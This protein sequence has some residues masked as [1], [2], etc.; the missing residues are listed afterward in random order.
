MSRFDL[1]A[2]L[3]VL[4]CVSFVVGLRDVPL[5][6]AAIGVV[7]PPPPED[8][9]ER[10][11]KLELV[12]LAEGG[13]PLADATVRVLWEQ[14][15]R[16]YLAGRAVTDA[17]G[18][19]LFEGL[20]RG[21]AWILVDAAGKARGSSQVV[22]DDQARRLE[23]VLGDSH[24]LAVSVRDEQ[25]EPLGE[26]TVLV[27]SADPL[28]YGA[29]TDPRG[30][31]RFEQLAASPWTI[32]VSAAGYESV[33]RSGVVSDLTLELRRLGSLEVRVELASGKPA[34]GASVLIAGSALW[35]ARRT[36][37]DATGATRIAGL[38]SGSYDLRATLGELVSPTLHGFQLERGAHE[39]LTLRLVTGRMVRALVVD[40]DDENA[41]V[42]P[43][44]DVVLAESGL[45]SFPLRGRT[46]SDGTVLLGPIGP[47]I[48]TLAA[49]AP[50][51]VSSSA[52]AVPEKL[53]GPLRIPLVRGGSLLGEVVDTKD[54]PVDGASVEVVGTDRDGL[55][56][57][58]TPTLLGF[59]L[60]HFEWSL[61]G[62]TPLIPAGELGVMPG[63]VPPIPPPGA[64]IVPGGIAGA[65]PLPAGSQPEAELEPWVTRWDGSFTARP[66]TPGRVRALVRHPAFVE[67]LSEVVTL[68]PGGEAKVKVVLRTGGA[69]E[70]RVVDSFGRPQAGVRVDLTALR[71][72]LERTTSTAN[73]GSFAFAAVPE[74]VS[75]SLARP[76]DPSRIVF[77]KQVQAKEGETTR[78]ELT[79]PAQRDEVRISV[80][81]EG[82]PV[83]AAQVTLLSVD[84][85][86][87]L[88]QTRFTG[89]E[90]VV[91]VSDARG[92]DL[93]V[94]VEAPG[95]TRAVKSVE[96]AP[97]EIAIVLVRGVIVTGRVTA[98]RGRKYLSGASV[99]IVSEGRRLAALT[100]SEGGFSLRDVEPGAVRVIVSHPEYASA[101]V[102]ATIVAT[103]RADRPFELPTVDLP[104]A[105]SVEGEVVDAAGKPVT[106]A[107]VASGIVP[108]YLPAGALPPG[109]AVTDRKGKFLLG[110]VAPGKLDLEAYAPDVGR[111]VAH[112][113]EVVSGRTTTGVRI[114][115]T[116]ARTDGDPAVGASLALTLGERGSGDDL[117][118]VIVQVAAGGEAERAGIRAGDLL[119]SVDG[120]DVWSMSDARLRMSGPQGSDVVLELGRDGTLV[121]LRVARESVRR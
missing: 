6:P 42:V 19:V 1:I 110:G 10:D 111:G 61:S 77:R 37:T 39:S 3:A 70:G 4:T 95:F 121:K 86:A 106:G 62:P 114:R 81:A 73:D 105:S 26:A 71:G 96:R 103:G 120:V 118:I 24:R 49:R 101:E 43:N 91:S 28:P 25:G 102:A 31:A 99:T 9:G 76:E 33:T 47:G 69:I 50:E 104:E 79:L 32:K 29:L 88:R 45:S 93:R 18:S 12:A 38:L 40:G 57:A 41:L 46:G 72:T 119:L 116:A 63:P 94:V 83:D 52:V 64:A 56:I 80:S 109:L 48:A 17:S 75:L 113:I 68:A 87:P 82:S 14:A 98:V 5:R 15:G 85:S 107:R 60:T 117:E 55:P 59:R 108:A 34:I 36:E 112:G 89:S 65:I 35:P 97:A 20:P 54:R 13:E 92:L 67:G 8:A 30:M 58:E 78:V 53:D 21:A 44:A 22:I 90:G 115:L 7:A 100:D 74:E 51:F 84:P 11:G 16:Y 66:V 27:T 23:M 2:F